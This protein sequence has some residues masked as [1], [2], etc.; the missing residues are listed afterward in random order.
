[1]KNRAALGKLLD[2]DTKIFGISVD[3]HCG[4]VQIVMLV[5]PG[6][7]QCS[8]ALSFYFNSGC[9]PFVLMPVHCR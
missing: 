6:S 5:Y 9:L 2:F 7:S 8:L 4:C 1:M 3:A